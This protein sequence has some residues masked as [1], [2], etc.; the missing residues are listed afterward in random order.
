MARRA[1]VV[2]ILQEEVGA[3]YSGAVHLEVA[4]QTPRAAAEPAAM[5]ARTPT[6]E[7]VEAYWAAV[8]QAVA[9]RHIGF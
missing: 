6:E 5:V 2:L 8:A 7:A 1:G 4:D 3:A 9:S